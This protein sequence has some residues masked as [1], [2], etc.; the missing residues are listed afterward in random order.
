MIGK[1]D[2]KKTLKHSNTPAIGRAPALVPNTAFQP[3]G[4]F[5]HVFFQNR[6]DCVVVLA[7]VIVTGV[8]GRTAVCGG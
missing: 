4:K 2:A 3:A 8:V 7:V 6:K 5:A 1:P